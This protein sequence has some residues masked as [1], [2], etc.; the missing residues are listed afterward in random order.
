M[1]NEAVNGRLLYNKKMSEEWL[2][3]L[4]DAPNFNR[5]DLK[6]LTILLA[7]PCELGTVIYRD[8]QRS[9]SPH[10]PLKTLENFFRTH[11]FF[12]YSL[13]RRCF[14]A[15][16]GFSSYKVPFLNWHYVLLPLEQPESCTWL[17]PL[18]IYKL[19]TIRG[20]C[21]AEMTNGLV[22]EIPS[23]MRSLVSQ[24]EKAVYALCYLRRDYSLTSN[25]NGVPLDYIQLPNTPFA[26][27]L[28]NRSLLQHWASE[29]GMFQQ[30]YFHEA[31]LRSQE[32][33]M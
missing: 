28:R 8:E 18:D 27:N 4:E 23:Q 20:V 24:A 30:R 6:K 17:N 10:S 25:Y 14:A 13:T 1:S 32:N 11:R 31:L 22:I 26:Q 5:Y 12:D 7:A 3:L 15:I 29:R 21:F 19:S 16:D 33:L 9:Y 2:I